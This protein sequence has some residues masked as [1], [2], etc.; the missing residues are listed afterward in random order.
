VLLREN[1]SRGDAELGS[2]TGSQI[3]KGE[4]DVHRRGVSTAEGVG[5]EKK[6]MWVLST[7][8]H[9]R[10]TREVVEGEGR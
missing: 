10:L 8:M 6:W 3:L 9:A 5:R 4:G 1:M 2:S 7:K